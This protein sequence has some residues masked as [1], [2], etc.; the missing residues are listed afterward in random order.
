MFATEILRKE[1]N[2]ILKMLAA[3]AL[4]PFRDNQ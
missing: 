4:Q 3:S 2:A 1:R